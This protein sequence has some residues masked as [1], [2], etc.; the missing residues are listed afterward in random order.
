MGKPKL[1]LPWGETS[2]LGHLLEQWK[3]LGV[4]QVAVVCPADANPILGEMDRIGVA[5]ENRILNPE[6]GRGMFSSVQCAANWPGWSSGITHW[7]ITLG[8]QPHLRGKTLRALL[9]FGAANANRICQPMRDGRRKHPVLLPQRHFARLKNTLA[10]DLKMFLV[11]H[12]P[13]LSG[14]ESDDAGLDF[15][16]DTPEEYERVQRLC[17][18]GTNSASVI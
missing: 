8:D 5:Q 18:G 14:F 16:M 15:D 10:G 7:L 2:V 9:D 13:E 17:F 3:S 12:A 11:E 4:R 6:P 1:L